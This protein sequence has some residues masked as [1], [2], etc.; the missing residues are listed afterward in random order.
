MTNTD[1]LPSNRQLMVVTW[2]GTDIRSCSRRYEYAGWNIKMMFAVLSTDNI[3]ITDF[4][5]SR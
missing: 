1:A 5:K 3:V 2:H 4:E